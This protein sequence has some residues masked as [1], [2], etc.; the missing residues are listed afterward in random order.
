MCAQIENQKKSFLISY[1]ALHLLA[2]GAARDDV[3]DALE[4]FGSASLV[5]LPA[6]GGLFVGPLINRFA[7]EAKGHGV[8]E[9]M[10][11]LVTRGGR[12][13]KRVVAV[14][15]MASSMTIGFGGAAGREGPMV[16][17]GS[18]IG[19]AI[20]QWARGV[21]KTCADTRGLRCRRRHRGHFQCPDRGGDFLDG[22]P[23]GQDS[24]GLSARAPDF[25]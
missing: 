19:S 24:H 23:D 22:S 5:L 7:P 21:H 3:A 8:P 17:I 18:A 20:G 14:K 13:R 11:A 10:T 25:A 4:I 9:V 15:V 12:I 6:L 1:H 2:T 16:Q